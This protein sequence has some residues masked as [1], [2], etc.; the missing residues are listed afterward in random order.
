MDIRLFLEQR[1][2][3][4]NETVGIINP[5]S[6][7]FTCKYDVNDDRN[8]VSFTIKSRQGLMIKRYLADHISKKLCEKILSDYKGIVTEELFEKTL[9]SIRLYE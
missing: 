9:K 6:C 7:D 8:P 4:M 5:S 1:E 2:S 3:E